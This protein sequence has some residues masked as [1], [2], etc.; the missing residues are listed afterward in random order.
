MNRYEDFWQVTEAALDFSC[1]VF[2]CPATPDQREELM[3]EYLR[4]QAYP[5]VPHALAE[6]RG[7][8]LFH[9]V[10]WFARNV[11][12]LARNAGL[13]ESFRGLL[14]ADAVKIYKPS[15]LG[16]STRRRQGGRRTRSHRVRLV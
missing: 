2:A 15:P 12:A 11:E 9:I 8:R 6:L 7:I 3:Q 10:E 13:G 1:A 14:S 5:D 4:L 16:I